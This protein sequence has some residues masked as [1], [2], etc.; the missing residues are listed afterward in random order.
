M[1]YP[2]AAAFLFAGLAFASW[3]L[4]A[5]DSRASGKSAPKVELKP[6]PVA[7]SKIITAG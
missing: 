7:K 6:T 2:L 3:Y 1:R 5:P 4:T